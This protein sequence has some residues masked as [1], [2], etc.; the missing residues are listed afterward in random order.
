MAR[1][2]SE[3]MVLADELGF[4]IDLVLFVD[5]VVTHWNAGLPFEEWPADARVK[6]ETAVEL[7]RQSDQTEG[8]L[9][10]IFS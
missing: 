6:V 4:P 5:A 3:T 9:G 10:G 8:T 7:L 1:S 2:A